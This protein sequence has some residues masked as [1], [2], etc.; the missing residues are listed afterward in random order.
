MQDFVYQL[1]LVNPY[2]QKSS[3]ENV[4]N[5]F[6]TK[7]PLIYVYSI[8]GCLVHN[9]IT[10]RKIT[11]QAR[12]PIYPHMS[13][14]YLQLTII[15]SPWKTVFYLKI[16]KTTRGKTYTENTATAQTKNTAAHI[17]DNEVQLQD[18]PQ[19]HIALTNM[20]EF[21]LKP[22]SITPLLCYLLLLQPITIS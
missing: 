4:P 17:T 8:Y 3:E 11:L 7:T 13:L 18:S 20:F 16:S 1:L 14:I 15:P 19:N 2:A 6:I 9:Y 21:P 10:V 5:R 22:Y 12:L